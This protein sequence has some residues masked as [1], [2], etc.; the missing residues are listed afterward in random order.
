MA[1]RRG[2]QETLGF[3]A[4]PDG[5]LRR[6]PSLWPWSPH[7]GAGSSCPP[8]PLGVNAL[9]PG[10]PLGLQSLSGAGRPGLGEGVSGARS[11]LSHTLHALLDG[12]CTCCGHCCAPRAQ[13]S[14]WHPVVLRQCCSR[15][16]SSTGPLP[17]GPGAG[18]GSGQGVPSP[19]HLLGLWGQRLLQE[20]LPQEVQVIQATARGQGRLRRGLTVHVGGWSGVG[21]LR[22]I[23]RLLGIQRMRVGEA[24]LRR[25]Q[26]TWHCPEAPAPPGRRHLGKQQQGC[27]QHSRQPAP[28]SPQGHRWARPGLGFYSRNHPVPG[29][30]ESPSREKERGTP[31]STQEKPKAET[32]RE[33]RCEGRPVHLPPS[34]DGCLRPRGHPFPQPSCPPV[35]SLPLRLPVPAA[36]TLGWAPPTW[37]L[38]HPAPSNPGPEVGVGSLRPAGKQDRGKAAGFVSRGKRAGATMC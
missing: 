15:G 11:P 25:C 24:V 38:F 8:H 31:I 16:Q 5:W 7:L 26:V 35:P 9:V 2:A 3:P 13:D 10:S 20:G 23:R 12:P 29:T 1:K 17:D 28:L 27:G 32:C 22:A 19:P 18:A 14:T 4:V 33:K 30:S 37:K 36:L 34:W 21:G 6:P